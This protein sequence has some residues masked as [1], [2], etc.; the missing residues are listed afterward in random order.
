[1]GYDPSVHYWETYARENIAEAAQYGHPVIPWL[2]PSYAGTGGTYIDKN[3]FRMQLDLMFELA[4]GIGLYNPPSTAATLPANHAWWEAL[5]EFVEYIHSPT[6]FTITVLPVNDAPTSAGLPD[7]IQPPGVNHSVVNVW[8]Y[9]TDAEQPSSQLTYS[10]QGTTVPDAFD[11][12]SLTD[13]TLHIDHRDGRIGISFIT[14]RA[15][16]SAGL[17]VDD[18]LMVQVGTMPSPGGGYS[19]SRA[20]LMQTPLGSAAF[21]AQFPG[22]HAAVEQHD[23]QWT[24]H[25]EH[26]KDSWLDDF[27]ATTHQ[28]LNYQVDTTHHANTTIAADVPIAALTHVDLE[29]SMRLFVPELRRR[30]DIWRVEEDERLLRLHQAVTEDASEPIAEIPLGS[31]ATVALH[32]ATAQRRTGP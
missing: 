4:D 28:D 18:L 7:L 23:E 25:A 2:S 15:S 9:F 19:E 3:F 24:T 30:S 20:D 26:R 12:L 10:I 6:Q 31:P 14:I 8:Q 16:D 21:V 27:G 29:R 22:S 13:G 32:L 17:Y 5:T 11:Q 1:M